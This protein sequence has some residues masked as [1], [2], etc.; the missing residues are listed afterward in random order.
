MRSLTI[1]RTKTK[2]GCWEAARI[3]I[4]DPI[5]GNAKVGQTR[6][7]FL[8]IVKNGEEKTFEISENPSRIYVFAESMSK[9]YCTD[10]YKLPAGNEDAY[11]TGQA[12]FNL[13]NGSVF[14][15]DGVSD[16]EILEHRKKSTQ[17]SI[18]VVLLSV[19]IGSLFGLLL[20]YLLK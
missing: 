11:L 4:E 19:A 13:I 3:Y 10:F 12:R 16:P 1:K 17:A 15:F 7:R 8:G 5:E 14:R 2:I 9:K 18:S 20:A 6:C